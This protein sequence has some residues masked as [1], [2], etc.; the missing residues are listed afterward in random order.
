MLRK[1]SPSLGAIRKDALGRQRVLL[2]G[3]IGTLLDAGL[4]HRRRK[5]RIINPRVADSGNLNGGATG[6]HK[7]PRKSTVQE[8]PWLSLDAEWHASHQLSDRGFEREGTSQRKNLLDE[9]HERLGITASHAFSFVNPDAA[10]AIGHLGFL[11]MI[12]QSMKLGRVAN[13]RPRMLVHTNHVGN[14][15]TVRALEHLFPGQNTNTG[16]FKPTSLVGDAMLKTSQIPAWATMLDRRMIR[17]KQGVRSKYELWEEVAQDSLAAGNFASPF[18]LTDD[19]RMRSAARLT[20]LGLQADEPFVALHIREFPGG[21]N[22][23]RCT[24]LDTFFPAISA[25]TASGMKVVRFGLKNMTPLPKIP[26][27]IDLVW[28]IPGD[29]TLDLYVIAHA[30]LFLT[31]VSGPSQVASWLGTPQV[32]TNVTSIGKNTLT[33]PAYTI[34]LPQRFETLSGERLSLSQTL[35][36]PVAYWEGYE[37]SGFEPLIPVK[38]TPE[39]ILNSVFEALSAPKLTPSA[40]SDEDRSVNAIRETLGAISKGQISRSFLEQNDTWIN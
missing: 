40:W 32:I 20:K 11:A 34:Y 7:G 13:M 25:L 14:W 12:A 8:R 22:D 26:G 33:N 16:S 23:H 4:F 19:Y 2:L 36:H 3:L 28:E 1:P 27:L 35:K 39:E 10:M 18:L 31:T 37:T 9:A 6:Y 15:E 17:T 30:E 38:N 24:P 21:T 5:R 29:Q